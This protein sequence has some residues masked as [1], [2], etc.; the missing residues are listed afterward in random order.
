MVEVEGRRK[1]QAACMTKVEEG[2]VVH[3]DSE[4]LRKYRRLIVELL[5]AERNHGCAVCVMNGACELQDWLPN[6][7]ST[8]CGCAT[9][10][11][12]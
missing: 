3:T 2:M 7:A 5:F 11:R 4:R 6:S 12:C 10:S 9:S 8:M 1:L